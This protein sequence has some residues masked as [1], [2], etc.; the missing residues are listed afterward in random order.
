MTFSNSFSILTSSFIIII[1]ALIIN[2]GDSNHILEL[3]ELRGTK[4]DGSPKKHPTSGVQLRRWSKLCFAG[5]AT[6]LPESLGSR[7]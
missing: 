5:C 4:K 3:F 2:K 7:G 6:S 1:G